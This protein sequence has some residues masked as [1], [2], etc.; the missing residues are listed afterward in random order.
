MWFAI[1]WTTK[2]I[3]GRVRPPSGR[4]CAAWRGVQRT[5]CGSHDSLRARSPI[6]EN[7]EILDFFA[8]YLLEATRCEVLLHTAQ[9]A[10]RHASPEYTS[11]RN[12]FDYECY[13][14]NALNTASAASL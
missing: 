9:S 8:F 5:R 11:C 7:S 12:H 3:A 10:V 14:S 4:E 2:E 1:T 6:M 13:S